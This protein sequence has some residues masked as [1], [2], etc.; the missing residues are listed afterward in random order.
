MPGSV[1]K[2][3]INNFDLYLER[4][5][6]FARG[7][8]KNPSSKLK[9][10]IVIPCYNEP[11]LMDTVKSIKNGIP[12]SHDTEIIVVVNSPEGAD[13]KSIR[14]NE[15]TIDQ[16][17]KWQLENNTQ[18]LSLY[19]L[20][21]SETPY[22]LAGA[23]LARK[24]GMDEAINRFRMVKNPDGVIISLDADT[25]CS[26]NYLWQIDQF[27]TQYPNANG[28]SINFEHQLSDIG[29]NKLREAIAQYELYLRY[30]VESLRMT[31]FPF[32]F[33]TVGSCFTVKANAYC[34][35]GGMN[36]RQAGEDF[37]FLQKLFY[38]ENYYEL[39][40]AFVYPSA[41]ISDRVVFGTGPAIQKI[42]WNGEPLNVY[43]LDSFLIFKDFF[44]IVIGYYYNPK[45][46]LIQIENLPKV[47]RVYINNFK[48]KDK[49]EEI[50]RNVNSPENFTKRFFRT[51]NNFFV[52]KGLNYMHLHE[53]DKKPIA[54][55]VN[56][57]FK[58]K[59]E[60]HVAPTLSILEI[61]RI[62]QNERP[63]IIQQK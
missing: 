32:S 44:E 1:K 52:V 40:S 37:Y 63:I 41:R 5:N 28:C 19:Y 2:K 33:H 56:D 55:A 25:I 48:T 49:L 59:G 10:C 53:F 47:F 20:N 17:K 30:Y 14:Q 34:K 61:L 36:T 21:K 60:K 31:G 38:L 16:I 12:I 18:N 35:Q 23:G 22:K 51:F 42:Y 7:I 11:T 8:T 46:C 39:N 50:K 43:C 54:S 6:G 57:L 27:Y 26:K 58:M 45:N 9:Y 62:W 4:Q 13:N 15:I 29:D 3:K 24:T